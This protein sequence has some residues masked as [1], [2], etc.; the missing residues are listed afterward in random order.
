MKEKWFPRLQTSFMKQIERLGIFGEFPRIVGVEVGN[1][2]Y[3]IF[4]YKTLIQRSSAGLLTNT[5]FTLFPLH[6]S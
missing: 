1:P 4:N 2:L 5:L 6:S 3:C